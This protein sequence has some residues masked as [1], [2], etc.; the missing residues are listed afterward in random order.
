MRELFSRALSR[1]SRVATRAA[2]RLEDASRRFDQS[3]PPSLPGAGRGEEDIAWF[4]SI[5]LGGRI[6]PGV[7]TPAVLSTETRLLHLPDDLRG[8][9]VL[10]I[11]TWDGFF[12]FEMERRGASS[13]TALDYYSWATDHRVYRQHNE[14][15]TARG[16]PYRAPH[17]IPEAWDPEGLPGKAGF[18]VARGALNSRVRPLV[19][20]FMNVDL[21]TLGSFD[22]VL[23]LGV[24]YHLQDPFLALRRLRQVTRQL[25]VI[26]T[27]GVVIPGWTQERLWMFVEGTEVDN[28]PTDWWMPSTAGLAAM[29]RAAGFSETRVLCESEEDA[30]PNPGHNVHFGRITMHALV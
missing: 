5:D 22:V 24:L 8:R 11:G 12:A 27:G 15:A 20:D 28:D 18:D 25:A 16:E 10:D 17:E 23:F 3:S 14:T 26:E 4:H 30:P 19:G 9:S 6:T 1:G 13:V 7:K 29:C 2:E 21:A